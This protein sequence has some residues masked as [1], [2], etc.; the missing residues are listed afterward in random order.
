MQGV[1]PAAARARLGVCVAEAGATDSA[2]PAAPLPPPPPAA[3][4]LRVPRAL[5]LVLAVAG[6]GGG[7][8]AALPPPAQ[9]RASRHAA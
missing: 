6:G 7:V 9:A 1:A 4:P 8:A 5:G 3:T 2:Q